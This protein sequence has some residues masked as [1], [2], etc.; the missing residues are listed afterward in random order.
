[1]A[2]KARRSRGAGAPDTLGDPPPRG[3][4]A[5]RVGLRLALVAAVVAALHWLLGWVETEAA[6]GR[7]ELAVPLVTGAILLLYALLLAVP[8]VPGV[9]I[10][11]SLLLLRGAEVA[12]FVWAA[13]T[14][15]L[16]L[17]FLAGRH[18]PPRALAE[19][20]NDLRLRRAARLMLRVSALSRAERLDLLRDRLPARAGP[21]LLRARYLALAALINLPG[22]VVLGG[23]GGLALVAGLS[24]VFRTA[25]TLATI[26]L[27][28]LPVPAT[29]WLFGTGA[30]SAWG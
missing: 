16:A 5:R 14:G 10:A 13:T 12:P 7:L 1:M 29:A 27:A 30:L 19:T 26:A 11:V 23:G 17:A 20:L 3:V 24:G 2:E 28:A 8:F 18:V 9:E 4:A 25:P 15:G 21:L 22:N 6:N